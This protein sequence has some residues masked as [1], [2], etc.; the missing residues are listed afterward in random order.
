M[1]A[2]RSASQ[3]G[4][5]WLAVVTPLVSSSP[6]TAQENRTGVVR[7]NSMKRDYTTFGDS[8]YELQLKASSG[9][10]YS[11]TASKPGAP[12][13]GFVVGDEEIPT[14]YTASTIALARGKN[15]CR[16]TIKSMF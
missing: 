3:I 6:A 14:T 15:I 4:A 5:L 16:L 13:D 10:F 8:V 7:I 2:W 1:T 12:C 9:S 11:V